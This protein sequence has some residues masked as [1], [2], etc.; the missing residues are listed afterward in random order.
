VTARGKKGT[1][2][3]RARAG[4]APFDDRASNPHPL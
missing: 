1:G 4:C 2:W 3:A